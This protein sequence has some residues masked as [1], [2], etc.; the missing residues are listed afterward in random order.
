MTLMR[1]ENAKKEFSL[2][3]FGTA[4]IHD[5]LSRII[6]DSNTERIYLIK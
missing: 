3:M 6:V 2:G 5:N 4:S 1:I